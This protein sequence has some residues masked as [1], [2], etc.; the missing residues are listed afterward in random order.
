[1]N[2]RGFL[3]GLI[4]AIAAPA[5]ITTPGL[6]MPVSTL[7]FPTYGPGNGM[8]TPEMIAAE[9]NRK[10]RSRVPSG[11]ASTVVQ[12][13]VDVHFP[14]QDMLLSLEEFSDRYI[15]PSV[16]ALTQTIGAGRLALGHTIGHLQNAKFAYFSAVHSAAG[17]STRAVRAYDIWTDSMPMRMDVLHS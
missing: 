1:M 11:F 8:L 7:A 12:S 16:A 5:V 9:F 17:V 4:A 3:G 6:L 13:H 2:R 10:M 15:A 14:S